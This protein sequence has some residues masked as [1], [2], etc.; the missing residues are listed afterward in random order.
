[1]IEMKQ[2]ALTMN[3]NKVKESDDSITYVW[4]MKDQPN[5]EHIVVAKIGEKDEI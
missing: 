1:M 3:F 4:N 5:I 2:V